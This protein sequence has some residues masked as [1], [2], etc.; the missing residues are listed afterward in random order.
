LAKKTW[1]AGLEWLAKV[2]TLNWN[3]D[4]SQVHML[5]P[6]ISMAVVNALERGDDDDEAANAANYNTQLCTMYIPDTRR[7]SIFHFH[8]HTRSLE[9]NPLKKRVRLA[10]ELLLAHFSH[11]NNNGKNEN[12][13]NNNSDQKTS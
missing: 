5:L 1:L 9:L 8:F 13:E 2:A 10:L 4:F 12:N 7:G 3:F 11:T 6:A